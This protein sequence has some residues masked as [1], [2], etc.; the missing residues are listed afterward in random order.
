MCAFCGGKLENST[1]EYVE[2]K[3][4][5]I[6]VIQNIPCEKCRQCGEDYFSDEVMQ[7]IE[8]ILSQIQRISSEISV[9]VIDYKTRIA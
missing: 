4:N 7:Q 9:T 3:D 5:Y 8:W 6:V 2:K 1:T